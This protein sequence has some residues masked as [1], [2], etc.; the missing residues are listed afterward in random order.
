MIG[1]EFTQL[2]GGVIWAIKDGEI[3]IQDSIASECV[4]SQETG[5]LEVFAN[6][7]S[8]RTLVGHDKYGR[9]VI[10]QVEGKT[11]SALGYVGNH[12]SC[13]LPLATAVYL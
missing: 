2:V 11:R 1:G 10:L 9:V 12:H 13:L 4:G 8:S 3:Y 6:V 7:T 5:T